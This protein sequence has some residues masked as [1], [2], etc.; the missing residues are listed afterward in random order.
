MPVTSESNILLTHLWQVFLLFAIPVG[1]GIPAGVILANKYG[2]SVAVMAVLYFV[3][4]VALAFVF[5]PIMRGFALLGRDSKFLT[6]FQQALRVSTAKTMARY[7]TKPGPFM[8]IMIAFGV[9][10][11]TG[12]AAALAQGH[13]FITGWAVAIAGDMIFFFLIMASTLWLNDYLGD[14]TWAAVIIMML[15][16]VIPPLIRRLFAKNSNRP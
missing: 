16:L 4:D 15:M 12:R 5:E 1:G 11:M 10:P 13:G 14:G 9:D 6:Q 7:G 2:M 8:L 3:S